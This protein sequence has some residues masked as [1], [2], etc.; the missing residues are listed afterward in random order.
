MLQTLSNF[1][2]QVL[3]TIMLVFPIALVADLLISPLIAGLSSLATAMIFVLI[4]S[5]IMTILRPLVIKLLEKL[6]PNKQF[7]DTAK[8]HQVIEKQRG[9]V[10]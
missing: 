4:I 2:K 3:I 7:T 8:I 10:S 1:S 9:N 5:P 6:L